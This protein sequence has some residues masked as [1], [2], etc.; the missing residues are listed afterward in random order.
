MMIAGTYSGGRQ[1]VLRTDDVLLVL[2]RTDGR[3]LRLTWRTVTAGKNRGKRMLALQ[4]WYRDGGGRWHPERG[5]GIGVWPH[6]VQRFA[7]AMIAA[8][9]EVDRVAA[10]RLRP[11]LV[12]SERK[13]G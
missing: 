13:A 5:R 12:T 9:T 6:E 2:P 7:E 10:H 8:V 1:D 3:E 4:Y 11:R